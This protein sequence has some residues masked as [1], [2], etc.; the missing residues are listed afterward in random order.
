MTK[1]LE[2]EEYQEFEGL[3]E[4]VPAP[5]E[6]F[7]KAYKHPDN[8]KL[9]QQRLER[10]KPMTIRNW[11]AAK[12]RVEKLRKLLQRKN[13]N[14]LV[15]QIE[16]IQQALLPMIER[17]ITLRQEQALARQAGNREQFM[18]VKQQLQ[19]LA[20]VGSNQQQQLARLKAQLAPL[21]PVY[22]EY[23]NLLDRLDTHAAHMRRLEKQK[24]IKKQ[25][26]KESDYIESIIR[27][28]WGQTRGCHYAWRDS[29]GHWHTQLPKFAYKTMN[30]H[31]HYFR[32]MA[33]KRTWFGWRSALPY[34]VDIADLVKPETL[35]NIGAATGR[36]T[37]VRRNKNGTHI[38]I[39]VHRL[40]SPDG[41]PEMVP[42]LEMFEWY[43]EEK[44]DRVPFPAG[45]GEGYHTLW[46]DFD[47]TPHMLVAGETQS[48]KSNFVNAMIATLIQMHSPDDL[49]L[50][51]ID[52]KGG[53]EFTHWEALPHL[54]TPVISSLDGV[55]PTLQ[56][57]VTI[58]RQ[59][60]TLLKEAKVKNIRDYNK[61]PDK[62]MTRLITFIDEMISLINPGN[63]ALTAQIHHYIAE[64]TAMGR[65][66]GIH[67]VLCTQYPKKEV[68]PTTI[69]S[70]CDVRVAGRMVNRV[71]SQVVLDRG[72]A[73]DLP[74]VPGRMVVKHGP[75]LTQVQTPYITDEE[76]ANAVEYAR[77]QWAPEPLDEFGSL[78]I[79][80]VT[81]EDTQEFTTVVD[82]GSVDNF[83]SITP[84]H[85]FSEDH[86]IR[87]A[88]ENFDGALKAAR[89]YDH[90]K[91][92]GQASNR[93]VSQLVKLVIERYNGGAV[94]EWCGTSY[95]LV[96]RPGNFWQFVPEALPV[97]P[98]SDPDDEYADD[99]V[100]EFD[101]P[102][103][104]D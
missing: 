26:A 77:R 53:V 102:H 63:T 28:V 44:H 71:N 13:Y 89:I 34:H 96:K 51:L 56:K 15:R 21:Q 23:R 73:A 50:C 39:M 36:K 66:V 19:G 99:V 61:V 27:Q 7:E 20:T 70:Q 79:P 92:T 18:E 98:E 14:D 35:D 16:A 11:W 29:K 97:E 49:K 88:L 84:Y 55:L 24:Q 17:T 76:V 83:D 25:L 22:E 85:T 2:R 30:A 3:K 75:R 1:I 46:L 57:L 69:K 31:A 6:I 62:H 12:R 9:I 94:L 103:R 72:D 37:E 104:G 91:E 60:L 65:A 95:T 40:D 5:M 78:P 48:G 67:M 4:D 33:S 87:L 54:L 52:N 59:R 10:F 90:I 43:P 8:V 74:D 81:E 93:Q 58:M 80:E 42:F 32:L 47:S 101:N 82:V 45:V 68:I 38:Y 86:V 41:M 64:L 100:M